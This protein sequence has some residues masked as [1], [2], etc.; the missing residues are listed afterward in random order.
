MASRKG[1]ENALV[2]DHRFIHSLGNGFQELVMESG[3]K[4]C[5]TQES[6][7]ERKQRERK[8]TGRGRGGVV[9]GIRQPETE[10]QHPMGNCINTVIAAFCTD[11]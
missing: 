3:M 10:K 7:A 11:L 1:E 9:A 6:G 4:A 5:S 8:E 2:K